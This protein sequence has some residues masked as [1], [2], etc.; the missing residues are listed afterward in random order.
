M[1]SGSSASPLGPPRQTPTPRPGPDRRRRRSRPQKT[2]SSGSGQLDRAKQREREGGGEGERE[3][4][5]VDGRTEAINKAL[6]IYK[7]LVDFNTLIWS[8]V[9]T[10]SFL[11]GLNKVAW[12][13]AGIYGRTER[14][15]DG[16]ERTAGLEA[17]YSVPL[18]RETFSPSALFERDPRARP[19]L[20]FGSPPSYSS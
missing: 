11:T 9:A 13:M 8:C 10:F 5:S 20:Q 2:V 14:A 17:T 7:G 4:N 3:N 18:G 15:N 12:D 6:E 19:L 1:N 16:N